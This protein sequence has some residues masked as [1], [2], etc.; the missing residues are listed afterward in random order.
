MLEVEKLYDQISIELFRYI[1]RLS[2]D[3]YIAEEIIQETF[4][5]ALEQILLGKDLLSKAWFY[6]VAKN[7]FFDQIRQQS[8]LETTD[9]IELIA[10]RQSEPSKSDIEVN[11]DKH[12]IREVLNQMSESYRRILILR[13]YNSLTYEEI[14]KTLDIS[15]SQVKINLYRARR[16]FKKL[17]ERSDK[18]EL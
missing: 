4:Y 1:Y 9:E 6:A 5:R 10:D 11:I 18:Y 12:H 8:K 14:A 16:S 2:G 7:L 3:K 13:E 15:V 17:Y